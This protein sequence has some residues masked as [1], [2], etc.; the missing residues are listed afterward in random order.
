MSQWVLYDPRNVFKLWI[1]SNL[2]DYLVLCNVNNCL[3]HHFVVTLG[4]CGG[5]DDA[6]VHFFVGLVGLLE[7]GEV[8]LVQSE[9]FLGLASVHLVLFVDS[10]HWSCIVR[11]L[12][13]RQVEDRFPIFVQ[14]HI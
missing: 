12:L 5:V 13:S 2:T 6:L 8:I 10:L 3:G 7:L 1:L 9:D 14:F 4:A 11:L